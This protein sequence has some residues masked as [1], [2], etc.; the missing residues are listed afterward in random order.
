MRSVLKIPLEEDRESMDMLMHYELVSVVITK[1]L[2][3]IVN[4]MKKDIELTNGDV[5]TIYEASLTLFTF[6]N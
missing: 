1:T 2:D 4:K 5:V 6:I 3:K